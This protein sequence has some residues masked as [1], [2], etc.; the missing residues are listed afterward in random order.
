[1]SLPEPVARIPLH[2]YTERRVRQALR[3]AGHNPDHGYTLHRPQGE[4]VYL[5][6]PHPAPT[7][8]GDK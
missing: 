5:V 8:E 3:K 4:A 2:E 6:L 7:Q 1:M